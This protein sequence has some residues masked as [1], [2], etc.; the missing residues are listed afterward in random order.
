[1]T[2]TRFVLIRH[3]EST[4][5]AAG[6]WQGRGDPPL[7][8]RGRA[9]AQRLAAGLARE[10]IEVVVASDLA[11]AA[12][13]AA[14]LGA[15]LGLAPTSDERLRE[16]DVG[17]WTGLTRPEIAS[18]DRAGLDHFESGAPDARAGGGECRRELAERAHAA[19]ADVAE[20]FAGRCIAVVAHLGV[21]RALVPGSEPANAEWCRAAP[22]E[23]TAGQCLA[24]SV[25]PAAH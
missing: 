11:R 21:V 19:V 18:R 22:R 6:R 3:G 8:D 24:G 20:R 25:R 10:G 2:A 12:E 14:I 23:I 5:N 17:C 15:A 16:L 1:V 9:Q 13:T 4:W 7:S